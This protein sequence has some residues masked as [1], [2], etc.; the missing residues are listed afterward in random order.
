MRSWVVIFLTL[1]G[2]IYW[3]RRAVFK[4]KTLNKNVRMRRSERILVEWNCSQIIVL[5]YLYLEIILDTNG[6]FTHSYGL[7]IACTYVNKIFVNAVQILILMTFFLHFSSFL[8]TFW[9]KCCHK[10]HQ[11]LVSLFG[12]P[13]H[14]WYTYITN[15][16]FTSIINMYCIFIKFCCLERL[17]RK[18]NK[19]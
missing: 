7:F 16:F 2:N 12:M 13:C 8:Y 10:N 17:K 19:K 6:V 18:K 5:L 1:K 9:G 15:S 3:I 4:P 11:H 14:T